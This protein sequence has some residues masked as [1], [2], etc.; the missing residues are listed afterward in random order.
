VGKQAGKKPLRR[1]R[2]SREDH[3]K[4]DF[5]ETGWGGTDWIILAQDGDLVNTVINEWLL[6]DSTP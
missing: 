4:M 5:R 1:P 6:K 2:Y 3:I